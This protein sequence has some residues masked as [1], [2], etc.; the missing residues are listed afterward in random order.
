MAR[1]ALEPMVSFY[2]PPVPC[3]H[4]P[5][6]EPEDCWVIERVTLHLRRDGGADITPPVGFLH[7]AVL[8]RVGGDVGI[9][10]AIDIDQDT[11]DLCRG[12]LCRDGAWDVSVVGDPPPRLP[13]IAVVHAVDIA[14]CLRGRGLGLLLVRAAL[15][16]WPAHN[17]VALA[18]SYACW[19]RPKSPPGRARG[20]GR[21]LARHWG[22]VGFVP[23]RPAG[24][25]RPADAVLF[26]RAGAALP[27]PPSLLRAESCRGAREGFGDVLLDRATLGALAEEIR[28]EGGDLPTPAVWLP[29][30]DAPP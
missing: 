22:R 3:A 14:P 30:P 18:R 12:L 26:R 4:E 28:A 13:F 5:I 17:F 29:G 20:A 16:R 6:G 2:S 24:G 19:K 15:E 23:V 8:V 9:F 10:D 11:W 21:A 25:R 1:L 7:L 27:S